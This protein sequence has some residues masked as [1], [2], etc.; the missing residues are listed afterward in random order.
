MG[1]DNNLQGAYLNI[2]SGLPSTAVLT[3]VFHGTC[4]SP[5]S[6]SDWHNVLFIEGASDDFSMNFR[7]TDGVFNIDTSGSVPTSFA[8]SPVA[9]DRYWAALTNA[10]AGAG[11]LNGYWGYK[12][13]QIVNTVNMAGKSFAPTGFFFQGNPYSQ[14]QDGSGDNLRI[15]D[16]VVL[17]LTAILREVNSPLPYR[18]ANLWGDFPL[19]HL[20]DLK[21]RVGSKIWVVTGTLTSVPSVPL[22]GDVSTDLVVGR[23]ASYVAAAELGQPGLSRQKLSRS[24]DWAAETFLPPSVQPAPSMAGFDVGL[25]VRPQRSSNPAAWMAADASPVLVPVASVPVIVHA[26]TTTGLRRDRRLALQD[27][28]PVFAPVAALAVQVEAQSAPQPRREKRR[29]DGQEAVWP[30]I[31]PDVTVDMFESLTLDEFLNA[32]N[33]WF[34]WDSFYPDRIPRRVNPALYVPAESAPTNP[35][36]GLLGRQLSVFPDGPRVE[37]RA[38]DGALV[39]P[40]VPQQ[41]GLPSA[42]QEI[43]GP[44]PLRGR[45]RIVP[46]G[47]DVPFIVQAPTAPALAWQAYFPDAARPVKRPYQTDFAGPVFVPVVVPSPILAWDVVY[48]NPT[49]ERRRY[50]A[51]EETGV[52]APLVAAP[53][54]AHFASYFPDAFRPRVRPVLIE[55]PAPPPPTLFLCAALEVVAPNQRAS[56]QARPMGAFVETSQQTPFPVLSYP[57]GQLRAARRFIDPIDASRVFVETAQAPFPQLSY[58]DVVRQAARRLL[59][60]FGQAPFAPPPINTALLSITPEYPAQARMLARRILEG[61]TGRVDPPPPPPPAPPLAFE[62][63][64]PVQRYRTREMVEYIFLPTNLMPPRSTFIVARL[65]SEG[66]TA[67]RLLGMGTSLAASN[68]LWNLVAGDDHPT[69]EAQ[70]LAPAADPEANPGDFDVPDLT[71]ATVSLVY[72]VGA[73]KY[74][75]VAEVFDVGKA[76]V[77]YAVTDADKA[78]LAAG[79]TYK[80]RFTA[81]WPDGS[82]LTFPNKKGQF[83]SIV[84]DEDFSP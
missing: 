77:R 43:A 5:T 81:R 41:M 30:T 70:M 75:R 45:I 33:A 13:S 72:K 32:E 61:M 50:G 20:R 16:G 66:T 14:N 74:S 51:M 37:R 24:L 40:A 57:D 15:W 69:I 68:L 3:A 23:R 63:V 44:T 42:A 73:A 67:V 19:L 25:T 9:G 76:Y 27:T 10:G 38:R 48:A 2:P 80:A 8:A 39:Q 4:R 52:V 12:G 62:G 54:P 17:D 22:G 18:T 47:G 56:G 82:R 36:L 26:E 65:Q 7:Q 84:V 64:Y 6:G 28:V 78:V 35:V 71:G 46:E 58:P 60:S 55:T 1:I 21:S 79:G 34:G 11:N 31:P 29:L 59:E 49:R 83:I 53:A